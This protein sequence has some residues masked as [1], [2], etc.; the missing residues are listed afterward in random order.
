MIAPATADCSFVA[1]LWAC[2]EKWR[3]AVWV[4]ELA[5]APLILMVAI[6]IWK[7]I[8]GLKAAGNNPK[9]GPPQGQASYMNELCGF[10]QN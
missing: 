2:A 9:G 1:G 3:M 8:E 10:R 4:K 7:T 5:T 6:G